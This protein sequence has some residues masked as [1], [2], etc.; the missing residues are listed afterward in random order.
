M[1][2]CGRLLVKRRSRA[3]RR[4]RRRGGKRREVVDAANVSIFYKVLIALAF[5]SVA[6]GLLRVIGPLLYLSSFFFPLNSMVANLTKVANLSA[7]ELNI[8]M[9]SIMTIVSPL[10][11]FCPEFT[12]VAHC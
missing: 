5:V 6:L 11:C 12:H 8:G 10:P 9:T 2:R 1:M 3:E 4:W 7:T